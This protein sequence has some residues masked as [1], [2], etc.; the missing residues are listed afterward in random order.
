[1]RKSRAT[2]AGMLNSLIDVLRTLHTAEGLRHL[3][4]TGGVAALAAIVFAETGLLVGFFLPGDSLLIT[5]GILTSSDGAGGGGLFNVWVLIPVLAAAAVVGDQ[6]G[7]F[8][9]RKAGHLV[10]SKKDSLF[11][12][13]KHFD[14]AHE[15]YKTHGGRAI[16]LAHFVPIF[17]TFVPFA[18]G[19]AEMNYFQFVRFNVFGGSFWVL[20]M[21]LIGHFLGQTTLADQL[22]K[23]IIVVV[24]VSVLPIIIAAARRYLAN[25]NTA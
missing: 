1:M 6:V 22:H 11:F 8:L 4:Q 10:F 16:I 15:F 24:F 3:I 17:R 5:A 19:V 13:R 2:V 7:F 20:S 14:A 21:L 9:G 25:K 23:I 12:K 18:A